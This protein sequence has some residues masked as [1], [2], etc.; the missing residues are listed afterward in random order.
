[1]KKDDIVILKNN[2]D[3]IEIEGYKSIAR[4]LINVYGV[5][6]CKLLVEKYQSEEDKYK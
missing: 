4:A 5:E 1:M 2:N 6:I 3:S